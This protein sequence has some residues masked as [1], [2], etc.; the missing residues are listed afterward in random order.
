MRIAC[1]HTAHSNVAVFEDAALQLGLPA[2]VLC[3]G[4][5]PDLLADAE[6]A[7]GVTAQIVDATQRALMELAFSADAVLLTCSTLGPVAHTMLSQTQVPVLRTDAALAQAAARVNGRVVVLCA[8]AT[9]VQ[10]TTELF[11]HA[12]AHHPQAVMDV[13]LVEG[14][15]ALFKAGQLSAYWVCVARAADA[16]YAQG[17]AQVVLAQASM[18]GA[19]QLVTAGP[20][21]LSSACA[22]LAAAVKAC[23]AG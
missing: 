19:A 7:G 12:A 3:H 20:R 9:T 11:L 5:R 4:V 13:R 10:P 16:A 18:G 17:A 21:P 14:A 2:G 6:A 23:Q 1:L 22:G 8:V 15:W